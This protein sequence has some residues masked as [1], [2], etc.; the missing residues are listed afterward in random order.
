MVKDAKEKT[1]AN[2]G[3]KPGSTRPRT[4]KGRVVTAV[5]DIPGKPETVEPEVYQEKCDLLDAIA[6]DYTNTLEQWFATA[7][8]K[9]ATTPDVISAAVSKRVF[10]EFVLN[11]F[12][13]VPA[14]KDSAEQDDD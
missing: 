11:T 2:A 7:P 3:D 10:S 9:F 1:K 8:D 5:E 13:I 4:R 6:D 14:S 12:N